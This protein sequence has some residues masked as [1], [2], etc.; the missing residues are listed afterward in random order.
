MCQIWP[1]IDVVLDLCP[2]FD[3]SQTLDDLELETM[4]DNNMKTS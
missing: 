4:I 3:A 1:N 2:T